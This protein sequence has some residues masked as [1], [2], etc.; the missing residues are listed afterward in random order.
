VVITDAAPAEHGR[1]ITYTIEVVAGAAPQTLSKVSMFIDDHRIKDA[2]RVLKENVQ[3]NHTEYFY[4]YVL[5]YCLG[6][7]LLLKGGC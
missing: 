6:R 3:L 7:Q 4:L 1:F 2:A 5:P